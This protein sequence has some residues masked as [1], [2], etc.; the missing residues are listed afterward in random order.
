MP[1]P[2][3]AYLRIAGSVRA[4]I[5]RGELGPHTPV[6]SERALSAEH[7]VSRMTARQ[8]LGHLEREGWVYR[9]RDRGTFVAEP[10]IPLRVGSFSDEIARSGH[11]PGARVLHAGVEEAEAGVAAALGLARGDRVHALQRLRTVDGE[12]LAIESTWF[13]EA[14][15]PDLL[16]GPLDGSLWAV[17]GER[18]GLVPTRAEAAIEAVALDERD[19]HRLRTRTDGPGILLTRRT[20]DA[21]GRPF[22][23]ARDLYRGD[24]AELRVEALISASEPLADPLLLGVR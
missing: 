16:S 4:R 10:R 24:R 19:A 1:S 7:G 2:T 22:E 20:F 14:L 8:A 12:P 23:F 18:A 13:P 3:P 9:R 11:R 17:L 5:E 6:P 21:D 15:C